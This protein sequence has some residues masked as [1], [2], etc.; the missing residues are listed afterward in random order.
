MIGNFFLP[1]KGRKGDLLRHEHPP[2]EGQH[3]FLEPH[4]DPVHMIAVVNLELMGNAITIERFVQSL[5]IGFQTVL[6]T[7]I[8]PDRAVAAQG[9]DIL[10]DKGERRV[11]QPFGDDVIG[12]LP[13]LIG[14]SR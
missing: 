1:W 7:D 8:Q 5:R 11:G 3:L 4:P 14:R 9:R 12:A 6:R 10:V 13:S 2:E